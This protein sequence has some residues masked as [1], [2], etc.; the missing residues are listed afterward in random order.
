MVVGTFGSEKRSDYT[1][2]GPAVNMASRIEAACEPGGVFISGEV[3]DY[4]DE[5]KLKDAGFYDLKGVGDV[6]LYRLVR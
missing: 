3:C 5:G 1:A 4:L 2:I 6:N